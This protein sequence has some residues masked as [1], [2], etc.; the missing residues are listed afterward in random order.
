MA[1]AYHEAAHAVLALALGFELVRVSLGE[2]LT[3]EAEYVL[4]GPTHEALVVQVAGEIAGC[5]YRD[6]DRPRGGTHDVLT[7]AEIAE[8]LVAQE[9]YGAAVPG[10]RIQKLLELANGDARRLVEE[11]WLAIIRVAEALSLQGSLDAGQVRGLV[12][13]AGN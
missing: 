8:A 7:A 10:L 3:G 4:Q 6:D 1:T 11:N 13:E 5:R 9:G 2:D 12:D